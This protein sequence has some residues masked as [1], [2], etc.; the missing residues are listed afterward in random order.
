MAKGIGIIAGI[1]FLVV[2]IYAW[3]INLWGFGGAAL[4]FLKG[5]IMWLL[6]L[7]GALSLVVGLS[8]LKN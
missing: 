6:L 4:E 3:I 7:V 2:P 5:G 8:D 1:V